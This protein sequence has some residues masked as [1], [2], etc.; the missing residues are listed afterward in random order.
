MMS[1]QKEVTKK[2]M[3]KIESKINLLKHEGGF[4]LIEMLI[5]VAIIGILVAIAVPA[6]STAKS[7]AQNAKINAIKA[8]VATAKTRYVLAATGSTAGNTAQFTDF[9]QYLLV[10]GAAPTSNDLILGSQNNT[11]QNITGWGTYPDT[12]GAATG[13]SF[14]VTGLAV[15]N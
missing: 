15:T 7:D 6:L 9:S 11:G 1:L 10:N 14:A 5:V 12:S 4:T 3:K 2:Y 8:S 13:V